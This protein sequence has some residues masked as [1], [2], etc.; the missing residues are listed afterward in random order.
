MMGCMST[1]TAPRAVIGTSS[2]IASLGEYG[3]AISRLGG[4]PKALPFDVDALDEQL[5]GVA[6]VLVTGGGDVDPQLYGVT[7]NSADDI[8]R[9]RDDYEIALIHEARRRH[10]PTLC[11]CRGLQIANV[12]FGGT[13]IP[14]IVEAKG[15]A[16]GRIHQRY[17]AAGKAMRG[18]FDDHAVSIAAGSLLASIVGSPAILT[19]SRHHQAIAGLAGDLRA[20]G[21]SP[22]GIIEAVE[23]TFASPFWLGVQWH[24]E[25]TLDGD[26]G[27]SLAIFE[28]FLNAAQTA[29]PTRT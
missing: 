10:L 27:S 15:S 19:G 9:K 25:S 16:V 22:H 17:D 8:D 12:A 3:A 18:A 11:I 26:D 28:R 5:A 6:G 21:E 23:A 1:V 7:T 24:P 2:S 20:V 14:D 13:L 4:R 29:D